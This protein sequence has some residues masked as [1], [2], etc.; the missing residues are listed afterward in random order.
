[1]IKLDENK[2]AAMSDES[3]CRLYDALLLVS[4]AAEDCLE[5]SAACGAV[6]AATRRLEDQQRRIDDAFREFPTPVR[7]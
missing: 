2:L 5:T 4:R 1:M 7:R 3:L 6:L